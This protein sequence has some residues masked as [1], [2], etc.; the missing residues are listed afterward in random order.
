MMVFIHNVSIWWQI[1]KKNAN[2]LSVNMA[3]LVFSLSSEIPDSGVA[4]TWHTGSGGARRKPLTQT[5][6]F[7]HG[8]KPSILYVS[9]RLTLNCLLTEKEWGMK[10]YIIAFFRQDGSTIFVYIEWRNR[11]TVRKL[12]SSVMQSPCSNQ[13]FQPRFTKNCMKLEK[14]PPPWFHQCSIGN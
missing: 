5:Q 9:L 3:G 2:A 14:H 8:S 6:Y 10:T 7:V 11:K 12:D 1:S 4:I 13:L